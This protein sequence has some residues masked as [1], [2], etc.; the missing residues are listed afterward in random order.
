M[1]NLLNK[2]LFT[3]F[4]L[5]R[6][7]QQGA[8]DHRRGPGVDPSAQRDARVP[9]SKTGLA[10]WC[11]KSPLHRQELRNQLKINE[12]DAPPARADCWLKVIF[13]VDYY[14]S[15]PRQQR[16]ASIG[17][18]GRLRRS[19]RGRNRAVTDRM[20]DVGND[21]ATDVFHRQ[22]QHQRRAGGWVSLPISI[23]KRRSACGAWRDSA[24]SQWT[25]AARSSRCGIAGSLGGF[26]VRSHGAL[27]HCDRHCFQCA[28]CRENHRRL[29]H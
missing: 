23:L 1:S 19:P 2:L 29:C 17:S 21:T 14:R 24:K 8:S 18:H 12:R 5:S 6:F 25:T 3:L 4:K 20:V 22:H 13:P 26:E 7:F 11:N 10:E 28:S 15:P 9:R 16:C 27:D